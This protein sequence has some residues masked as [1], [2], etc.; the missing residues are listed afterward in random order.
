MYLQVR[1]TS[2]PVTKF[3]I[4]TLETEDEDGTSRL[5][6]DCEATGIPEVKGHRSHDVDVSKRLLTRETSEVY[7]LR[8][9]TSTDGISLSRGREP[10]ACGIYS[11]DCDEARIH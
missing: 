9:Q 2:L 1:T 7:Q 8:D 11:G 5:K 6:L 4:Q 10:C 3:L